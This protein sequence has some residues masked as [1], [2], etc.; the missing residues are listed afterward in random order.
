M[1]TRAILLGL[2]FATQAVAADVDGKWSGSLDTPDGP[3]QV[4]YEFKASGPSLEGTTTGPDGAKIAIKNGKIEGD[5]LSFAVDLN[6]NGTPTTI[7]Y[8]GVVSPG[9]IKLQMDFMGMPMQMSL[10]KGD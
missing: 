10:K 8:A 4:N 3:V 7:T 2:L 1:K 9:E 6:F 5:K